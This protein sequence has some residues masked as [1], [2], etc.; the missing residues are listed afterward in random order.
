MSDTTP[1]GPDERALA[2]LGRLTRGVL[3]EISNPLLALTGSAELALADLEQGSKLRDRL[4]T[5]QQT[6]QEITEIVRALQR[7][8]RS[9]HEE[10]TRV[11]L[12][13]AAAEAVALV[14]RVVPLGDVSLDV[15]VDG[16]PE[17]VA[18]P[19]LVAATLVGLLLDGL[20]AAGDHGAVELVVR[21]DGADAVAAV[22]GAGE[23]RLEAAG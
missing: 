14:R 4:E 7:F 16:E 15:R 18:R 13:D 5:V 21:S 10:A 3:H 23:L 2:V 1:R 17:V 12:A 20:A 22:T 19:G 8:V 6:G 9:Q 11:G